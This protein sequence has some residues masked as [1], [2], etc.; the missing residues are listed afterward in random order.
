[1]DKAHVTFKLKLVV[2]MSSDANTE[3][4]AED[5]QTDNEAHDDLPRR[6]IRQR[7]QPDYYGREQSHLTETPTTFKDAN[8]SQDRAKWKVAIK[9]EMKFLQENDVWDLVKLPP[10]RKIIGSK[11]VFKKKTGADS[12]VERYKAR[13]VAQG[14]TKKY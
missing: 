5:E 1:M 12:T 3:T 8:A 10:G 13:L 6:S 4:E 7:R 9:K 11:W 14:C 2:D